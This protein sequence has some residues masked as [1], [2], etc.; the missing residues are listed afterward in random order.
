PKAG[1]RAH[2]SPSRASG[3]KTGA[4]RCIASVLV[5]KTVQLTIPRLTDDL[6]VGGRAGKTRGRVRIT[7]RRQRNDMAK[8]VSEWRL[9]VNLIGSAVIGVPAWIV[10]ALMAPVFFQPWPDT[11]DPEMKKAAGVAVFGAVMCALVGIACLVSFLRT[12][13]A[14]RGGD[15]G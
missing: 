15:R 7:L 11:A 5:R 14:L 4:W 12:V 1:A 13:K 10:A 6:R 9:V 3:R 2:A 8:Q